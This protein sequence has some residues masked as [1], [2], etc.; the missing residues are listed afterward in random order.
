LR[1]E[2]TLLQFLISWPWCRTST[3]RRGY[4]RGGEIGVRGD[5]TGYFAEYGGARKL[6]KE[7]GIVKIEAYYETPLNGTFFLR[8]KLGKA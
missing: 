3:D 1:D 8:K 6:Y 4:P 5:E 7:Y 2:K